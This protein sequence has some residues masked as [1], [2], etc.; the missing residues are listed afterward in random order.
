M[1]FLLDSSALV[2]LYLFESGQEEIRALI[3]E[4]EI[5]AVTAIAYPETRAGLAAAFRQRRIDERQLSTAR[6][7]L[8][9]D[10]QGF[11]EIPVTGRLCREAGQMAEAFALRGY[12]SVHLAAYAEL[13][14]RSQPQP[15]L[16]TFDRQLAEAATQWLRQFRRER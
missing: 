14:R 10:W 7:D 13:S 2:K 1:T 5:V 8:E 15:E 3:G 11:Y 16:I 12:D 4:V 6:L 9:Q